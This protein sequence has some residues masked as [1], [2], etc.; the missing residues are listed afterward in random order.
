MSQRELSILTGMDSSSYLVASE[1]HEVQAVRAFTHGQQEEW[2]KTDDQLQ[3]GAFQKI[4]LAWLGSCMTLVPARLYNS[5]RRRDYLSS[6]TNLKENDTVLADVVP[7]LDVFLVYALAQERLAVWRRHFV[8]CRF[9]HAF[10][11][12]LHQL[13]SESQRQARP[14]M[15]A[16]I[17]D[18]RLG[19]F[20]LDKRQLVFCNLFDYQA[21]RDC[22]Y[23]ILLAYEQCQWQPK[24][25]PLKIFG[26]VMADSEIGRFLARY[27]RDIDF[28]SLPQNTLR[29]GEAS[30]QHP[31]HFFYDLACL[32]G[33]H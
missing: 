29:W 10:T 15:Y 28:L 31:A 21:V 19:V 14:L 7:E 11:P 16:Y 23:F 22:L 13:V 18:N 3:K 32:Q 2:W 33:Y 4:R 9:Y 6:L 17:K 1:D 12:I 26:E 30:T 27:I 8:G 25:V 20:A 24:Q 5:D